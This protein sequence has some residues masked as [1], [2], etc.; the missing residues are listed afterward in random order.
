MPGATVGA[1]SD[2]DLF[3]DRHLYSR[4]RQIATEA[5]AQQKTNLI[6]RFDSVLDCQDR[7]L[8]SVTGGCVTF[9]AV[10]RS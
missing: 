6:F 8:R 10:V 5:G 1:R 4:T 3:Q 9:V 7:G 2:I